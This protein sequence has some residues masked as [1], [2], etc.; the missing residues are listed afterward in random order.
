M[1]R[2][3]RS[4]A[5]LTTALATA[6]SVLLV[7]CAPS[8]TPVIAPTS[9]FITVRGDRLFEGKEEF[10]FLS[11]NVPNLHYIEDDLR[12]AQVM[13]FRWPNEYEVRDALDSIR[14]MGGRVARIYA[15]SVRKAD[16]PADMPRH[17]LGPAQFDD[18]AFETL[19]MVLDVARAKG[20]RLIIP[21]VDNWSW[22]GGV[23]EY[24]AFREKP[25]SAFW[26]D[27]QLIDDYKESVRFVLERV[28]TRNLVAYRDDP[29]ILAW[30]TGNELHCPHGWTSEIAA[31]MKQL[32]PNHLVLDGRHEQVLQQASL[33]DPNIDVL[34]THHYEN[35]PREMIAHIRRSAAMARDHK[36]Y[37]VGE[38]G[39]LSTAG[40][41]AVMD[42]ITDEGLAGGLVWSLR[43]H[44]RDGGFYWHSEPHGGDNFK[45]YHWPGF[46]SGESYDE[47]RVLREIRRRAFAIRG[48]RDPERGTPGAPAIIEVGSGGLLSWRG[49]AGAGAYDV[50]RTD[51]LTEAWR[52]IA[53]GV[54][55]AATQYRPLYSD[56]SVV[57]GKSYWYRVV[58]RNDAGRSPPSEPFGP[59]TMD[60]RTLV[61]E[62]WNGS[63]VFFSTGSLAFRSDQARRFKEDAHGLTGKSGAAV[64][65]RTDGPIVG[66]R[67]WA[68]AETTGDYLKFSVSADGEHFA[69][70]D[71]YMESLASGDTATYGYR[72]PL[73]YRLEDPPI[74]MR[75]LKVEFLSAPVRVT[76]I[77]IE[78][79]E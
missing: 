11:F 57:S 34:Q 73:R 47:T 12:F 36:P 64:V 26:T 20:V 43:F 74:G 60:H 5:P 78:Y 62:L 49:A 39:F 50:Q 55:D 6:A 8:P 15:L 24:A 13:P 41:T 28:N 61:D 32:D 44:S 40:M 66:G 2:P 25:R 38:F 29:T 53:T 10:R 9:A 31:Y 22:W 18:Q 27:R 45:A 3:G 16:D 4:P 17:V 76:R 14:Q 72:L 7:S 63:R 52:T 33:D 21:L 65:Y 58:A 1:R 51:S 35:D 30:E 23:N 71:P 48:I 42:T 59:V 77:E 68:F 37:L 67:V 19:D 56:Q 75:H 69:P 46:A 70:F 79:G 54:S